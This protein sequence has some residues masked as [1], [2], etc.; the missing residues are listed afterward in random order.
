LNE[1]QAQLE[2][3]PDLNPYSAGREP[4]ASDCRVVP[5]GA[6]NSEY[7]LLDYVAYGGGEELYSR[8]PDAPP[9]F[10][11]TK[12]ENEKNTITLRIGDIEKGPEKSFVGPAGA[13]MQRLDADRVMMTSMVLKGQSYFSSAEFFDL[14]S[15]SRLD[16]FNCDILPKPVKDWIAAGADRTIYTSMQSGLQ[17]GKPYAYCSVGMGSDEDE[18]VQVVWDPKKPSKSVSFERKVGKPSQLDFSQDTMTWVSAV[19]EEEKHQISIRQLVD[20]PNA[21]EWGKAFVLPLEKGPANAKVQWFGFSS[22]SHFGGLFDVYYEVGA[23]TVYHLYD[24]RAHRLA[25]SFAPPD[26][27]GWSTQSY[28]P[29]GRYLLATASSGGFFLFERKGGAFQEIKMKFAFESPDPAVK[30]TEGAAASYAS[31]RFLSED[32]FV[33]LPNRHSGDNPAPAN[34]RLRLYKIEGGG[35]VSYRPLPGTDR[36]EG[37]GALSDKD[38]LLLQM[39]NGRKRVLNLETLKVRPLSTLRALANAFP[40]AEDLFFDGYTGQTIRPKLVCVKWDDVKVSAAADPAADKLLAG[41]AAFC[42]ATMRENSKWNG[43]GITSDASPE[44]SRSGLTAFKIRAQRP[45]GLDLQRDLKTLLYIFGVEKVHEKEPATAARILSNVL[46]KSDL[47][48]EYILAKVIGSQSAAIRN[49]DKDDGQGCWSRTEAER[50]GV[51][52]KS[53]LDGILSRGPE[54]KATY[55]SQIY[56]KIAPLKPALRARDKAAAEAATD[57]YAELLAQK[58][59]NHG[60]LSQIFMSKLYKFTYQFMAPF[61]GE[62]PQVKSDYTL[63]TVPAGKAIYSELGV[64][65]QGPA[66]FGVVLGSH[67]FTVGGMQAKRSGYG[68]YYFQTGVA[69][70]AAGS[71]QQPTP[72]PLEKLMKEAKWTIKGAS[73]TGKLDANYLPVRKIVPT[74]TAFPT[75]EAA[76]AADKSFTGL[77]MLGVGIGDEQYLHDEYLSFFKDNG[78]KFSAAQKVADL[79][80][81]LEE[82]IKGDKLD[83]LVKEA[84]SDGDE[85]NVFRFQP[86]VTLLHGV[87]KGQDVWLAMPDMSVKDSGY[88]LPN[89]DFGAWINSRK[90]PFTYLNTSCWSASKAVWEIQEANTQKFFDIAST[91][92]NDTFFNDTDSAMLQ[93]IAAL[94]GG[95]TFQN[96]REK[97]LTKNAEFVTKEG[98][99]YIFPGQDE[100]KTEIEDKLAIP[101][102]AEVKV[103]DASGKSV[104]IDEAH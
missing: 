81:W 2:T 51:G 67:P 87:K 76:K 41:K 77:V 96:T 69:K 13:D 21:L 62:V 12:A 80:P 82:Q 30:D 58:V 46:T 16:S 31:A 91:T 71:Y 68:F 25:Q 86:K 34:A 83:Y 49:V 42:K 43:L 20:K 64:E 98:N 89:R 93:L 44:V 18:S 8:F 72:I 56:Y 101:F 4:A 52:A 85:K 60:L 102:S 59:R 26:A 45:A 74:E 79:R 94:L 99:F 5:T 75:K 22:S 103:V 54:G 53:Y 100:Y 29:S 10:I 1:V 3:R 33:A 48:Y 17:D 84:H 24:V 7:R 90:L 57:V 88:L 104:N 55:E 70:L 63:V 11:K 28:S 61:F 14:K 23:K 97:Y 92:A 27:E 35:N 32:S 78:Y 9:V 40:L 39:S 95:E 37:F 47:L 73:Y 50:I 19:Y 15:G 36:V 38:R 66:I 6:R 65:D